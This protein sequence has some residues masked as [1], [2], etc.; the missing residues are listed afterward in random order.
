MLLSIKQKGFTLIE[1]VTVIIIL[2]VI[3]TSITTFL[4]YGTQ[5]YTDAAE[6]EELISTAR[7]AI[8]RLNREVRNA[9][10]NSIR[11]HGGNSHCLEFTPIVKSVIYI[12][13]PVAPESAEENV[14]FLM[15]DQPLA[16]SIKYVSIY[17]L[18]ANDIYNKKPGVLEAYSSITNSGDKKIPSTVNFTESLHFQAESPTNRMYIIDE[19]ISYCVK[20]GSLYRYQG[21]TQYNSADY[22]NNNGVLMA[23]YINNLSVP[24]D[25]LPPFQTLPATLQR[26]AIALVQLRFVRNLEKIVFSNEIQVPNVP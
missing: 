13:I 18:N 4:R 6:R 7:F 8:E 2:G 5:S 20:N 22:P 16:P 14:D 9:L 26:N 1:L 12:D 19:P 15:L 3:A 11:T 24:S 23:D 21:Y 25:I 10:P 17:A